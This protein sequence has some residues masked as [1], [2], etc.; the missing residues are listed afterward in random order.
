[1]ICLWCERSI[2][3]IDGHLARTLTAEE[4]AA[5]YMAARDNEDRTQ[6]KDN[7]AAF[8]ESSRRE[9]CSAPRHVKVAAAF[10]VLAGVVPVPSAGALPA[11]GD[12]PESRPNPPRRGRRSA[13][14]P[15]ASTRAEDARPSATAPAG[16][17]GPSQPNLDGPAAF[18][19]EFD[20]LEQAHA[21]ARDTGG[22]TDGG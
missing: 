20:T 2:D 13:G 10:A 3:S 19:I 22:D 8:V 12:R 16:G 15:P 5:F 9:E 6:A 7:L 21:A 11:E 17:P 14:L 4:V 1:M 18:G